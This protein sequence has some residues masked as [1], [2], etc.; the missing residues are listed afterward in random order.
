MTTS[1]PAAGQTLL[2]VGCRRTGR[3]IEQCGLTDAGVAAE[4]ERAGVGMRITTQER[5]DRRDL[6]VP[7]EE[8]SR[9]GGSSHVHTSPHEK[10]GDD[11]AEGVRFLEVRH[12]RAVGELH[13]PGLRE[14]DLERA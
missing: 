10:L 1:R 11:A 3:L 9:R 2:A 12:V 13:Q 6:R 5:R 7:P 14:A 8:G 4:D